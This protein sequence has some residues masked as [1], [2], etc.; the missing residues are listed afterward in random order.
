M[1]K[2]IFKYGIFTLMSAFIMASC[3]PQDSDDHSLGTPDTVSESEVN[4]T[5]AATPEKKNVIVFTNTSTSKVPTAQLWDLGNG[6]TS[7]ANSLKGEYPFKGDYTIKLTLYSA[8][9]SAVTKT[10]VLKIEDDDF[11]LLDTKMYNALTGGFANTEGKTWV[12]DRA[13]SGHFGVFPDDN[14]WSWNAG[15]EEKANCSLYDQ[16]FTFMLTGLKMVWKN[17]G[18]IY[19]NVAGKNDLAT[20]G[21]PNATEPPA[22]D[23]DVEYTPKESYTFSISESDN[24]L[25]LGGEAFMGH[26]AGTSTYNISVL[27]GDILEITCKST[28]ESGNNWKYRFIPKYIEEPA[29]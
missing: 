16:E 14:S 3:N 1:M 23:W 11:S 26:Y 17:K 28:V 7:K 24:K 4:F 19:T 29:P 10:Q 22:G 5:F 18:K 6:V 12:Y 21:Y 15:P 27:N 25:I 9:G 2:N 13:R 8:D 20:K